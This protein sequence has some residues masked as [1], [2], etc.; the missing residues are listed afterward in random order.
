[1]ISFIFEI[2]N[3]FNKIFIVTFKVYTWRRWSIIKIL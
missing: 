2:R 3:P 1:M